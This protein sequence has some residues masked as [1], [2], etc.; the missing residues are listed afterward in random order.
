MT[1]YVSLKISEALIATILKIGN[2]GR[3]FVN[4]LILTQGRWINKVI[5]LMKGPGGG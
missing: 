3:S 5:S 2:I 4:K 1:N